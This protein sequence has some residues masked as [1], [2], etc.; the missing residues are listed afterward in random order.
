M[1]QHSIDLCLFELAGTSVRDDGYVLEAF[2]PTA[3][4]GE[5]EV[6]EDLLRARMDWHKQRVFATFLE[7]AGRATDPAT[8][9]AGRFEQ[10]Y[11]A[12]IGERGLQAIP[13]RRGARDRRVLA[14][15][16]ALCC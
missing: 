13:R 1:Q 9:L 16:R 11:A 8:A 3:R 10:H 5:L 7:E 2:L 15:E 14:P 12:V 6:T 4:E